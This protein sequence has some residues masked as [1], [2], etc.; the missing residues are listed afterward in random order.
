MS[1]L[2]CSLISVFV[3]LFFSQPARAQDCL[4]KL[5]DIKKT[6][7]PSLI[8]ECL[9]EIAEEQKKRRE[10]PKGAVV[11]F[12][13]NNG[14]PAN[15]WREFS[16]GH[17][18]VLVGAGGTYKLTFDTDGRPIFPSGG[19]QSNSITANNLPPHTHT[20]PLATTGQH[21]NPEMGNLPSGFAKGAAYGNAIVIHGFSDSLVTVAQPKDSALVLD[22]RQPFIAVTFCIKE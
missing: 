8:I 16:E 6:A 19:T 17:D 18:R 7:G 4:E 12:V 15:G 11:P 20:L 14:C 3:L 10:I 9:A 21:P 2:V 5:V 13:R 22:N 1:R